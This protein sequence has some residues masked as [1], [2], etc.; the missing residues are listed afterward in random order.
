MSGPGVDSAMPRPGEM[1]DSLL[2]DIGEHGIRSTKGDDRD[3]AEEHAQLGVDTV[4]AEPSD[5]RRHRRAPQDRAN[6][7]NANGAPERRQRVGWRRR[8]ES[9]R[10]RARRF[11][12][13]R[14]P[15]MSGEI[16]EGLRMHPA[17]DQSDRRRHDDDEGE[18]NL[19][20]M[21]GDE[22]GCRDAHHHPVV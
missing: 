7:S 19:E 1:L 6:A 21:N 11:V 10:D 14:S 2:G 18:G 20:D 8:V 9:V 4:T 15:S 13:L 17:A 5:E 12:S 3:L 16:R 22:R